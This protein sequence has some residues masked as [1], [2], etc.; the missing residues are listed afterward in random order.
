MADRVHD[1]GPDVANERR[2]SVDGVASTR[3]RIR[4]ADVLIGVA[5]WTDRTLTAPGVFYPTS[6]KTPEDRLRFYSSRFP[7]VEVDST[8]YAIPTVEYAERWVERTPENFTF[9]I[10]AHALMTGHAT[11]TARLPRALRDALPQKLAE[12]KRL[13]AKDLPVELQAE[14]WR[15]F[16]DALVPLQESVKMGA[17]LLQFA[18]WVR[19]ARHTPAMLARARERLGDLPIAVEFRHPSWLDP[20]LRERLWSQLRDNEMTYVV[21]DTPPRTE[22]SVPMVAA[23]TTPRLAMLRLHG[24][25]SDMWGARGASVVEKYRYLYDQKELE[26]W[27]DVIER[28]AEQA[29]R[30]HV[31]FNNCYANYGVTN[32]LEFGAL[33]GGGRTAALRAAGGRGLGVLGSRTE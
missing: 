19:P 1:P 12:S 23:V 16:H 15:Q 13:Y 7:L 31:V 5:S 9:N 11:E 14:V 22:T 30:I 24:R 26:E 2:D 29:E 3:Q 17:V 8:Y 4:G 21:V 28:L 6:V 33:L 32:A 18:P 20:R 25:R 10:K 27:L